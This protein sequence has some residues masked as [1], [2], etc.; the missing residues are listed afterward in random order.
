MAP[1]YAK[2]RVDET[3]LSHGGTNTGFSLLLNN[4]VVINTAMVFLLILQPITKTSKDTALNLFRSHR[5]AR[6]GWQLCVL[7]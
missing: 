1:T 5:L 6:V 2:A 3:R 7:T 4:R